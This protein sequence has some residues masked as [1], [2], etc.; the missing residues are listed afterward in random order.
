[1]KIKRQTE[2]KSNKVLKY[3]DPSALKLCLCVHCFENGASP[4]MSIHFTNTGVKLHRKNRV[5]GKPF[6]IIGKKVF[7]KKGGEGRQVHNEYD[8]SAFVEKIDWVAMRLP[9][10]YYAVTLQASLCMVGKAYVWHCTD[11]AEDLEPIHKFAPESDN[12]YAWLQKHL[13]EYTS[14]AAVE[15]EQA[16]E[17]DEIERYLQAV[18]EDGS[19]SD[20]S[21]ATRHV[22]AIEKRRAESLGAHAKRAAADAAGEKVQ[23]VKLL[24]AAAVAEG[25]DDR[26]AELT[27]AVLTA[28]RAAC[29]LRA[30][31][32]EA[33]LDLDCARAGAHGNT[34]TLARKSAVGRVFKTTPTMAQRVAS[35]SSSLPRK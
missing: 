4:E 19:D 16:M 11:A 10:V 34:K 22:R 9:G 1:M 24:R 14:Q 8:E 26:V 18:V 15:D 35:N 27:D 31:A 2:L 13:E 21:I 7:V 29:D 12:L 32:A 25:D 30:A 28:N 23:E 33:E 20:D 17:R 6:P 5:C 3:F